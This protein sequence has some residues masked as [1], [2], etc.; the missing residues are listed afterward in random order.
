MIASAVIPVGGRGSRLAHLLGRTPK[1]LWTLDG[2]EI[3]HYPL[4]LVFNQPIRSVVLVTTNA[5]HA[6]IT[7][8]VRANF[9]QPTKTDGRQIITVNA[10]ARGTAKATLAALSHVDGPCAYLNGDVIYPPQLL[11]SLIDRFARRDLFAIVA[12]STHKK[13]ITHP[14]FRCDSTGSLLSVESGDSAPA[15][16]LCSM[17]LAI[18]P[19]AILGYLR[20]LPPTAMTMDALSLA[21]TD[22]R[23]IMVSASSDYWFHL[24]T[25]T[26]LG[27]FVM[28]R[29]RI[30]SIG[31]ALG[32]QQQ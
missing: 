12:A 32:I 9:Q 18:L 28:N 4:S 13:A 31:R 29:D 3:L 7:D 5:N 19:R 6:Q 11:N 16:Y 22:R 15:G 24:A 26:D 25:P 30:R 8:F 23:R 14:H 27:E 20:Q 2:V 10:N 1:V 17:E 21:I